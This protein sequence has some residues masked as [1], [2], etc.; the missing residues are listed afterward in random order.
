LRHDPKAVAYTAEIVRTVLWQLNKTLASDDIEAT[1]QQLVNIMSTL[2]PP[3]LRSH[4]SGEFDIYQITS[5]RVDRALEF[6]QKIDFISIKK[7]ERGKENEDVISTSRRKGL[8]VT[9]FRDY[10]IRK[11]A[12][13]EFDEL[14][15]AKKKD[16]RAIQR[17]LARE[18]RLTER[19]AMRRIGQRSLEDFFS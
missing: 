14:E 10:F 4:K 18:Q 1:R 11:Q 6:L 17:R 16:E 9:N 7:A 15:K 8:Q 12:E 5:G 19:D 2:Y 3:Y 13:L